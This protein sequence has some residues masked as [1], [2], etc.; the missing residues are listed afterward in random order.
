MDAMVDAHKDA[1]K[2]LKSHAGKNGSASASNMGQSG[3]T[4]A[5]NT[6]S[7]GAHGTSGATGT[8]G[9]P[10]PHERLDQRQ[11]RDGHLKRGRAWHHGHNGNDRCGRQQHG[12]VQRHQQRRQ[13]DGSV[14]R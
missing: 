1:E 5:G 7:T 13:H 4:A 2:L 14:E 9:Q 8:T 12:R 11:H 10:G 3:S 6:A